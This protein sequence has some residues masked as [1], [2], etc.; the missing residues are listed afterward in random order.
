[1]RNTTEDPEENGEVLGLATNGLSGNLDIQKQAVLTPGLKPG[2]KR[3]SKAQVLG[4]S[5]GALVANRAVLDASLN[6]RI[7]GQTPAQISN[8]RSGKT[9]VLE[10]VVLKQTVS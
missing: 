2:K 10:S 7:R 5:L 1:M 4:E 6:Q 3:V 8:G 9:D